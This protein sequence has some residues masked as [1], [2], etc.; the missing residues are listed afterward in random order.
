MR[1]YNFKFP[2]TEGVYHRYWLLFW[3]GKLFYEKGNIKVELYFVNKEKCDDKVSDIDFNKIKVIPV[4]IAYLFEL[5]VGFV[6]DG[7]GNDVASCGV[8]TQKE[9]IKEVSK[10]YTYKT[11]KNFPL[12]GNKFFLKDSEDVL[13]DSYSYHS[14]FFRS[15]GR[16][17]QALISPYVWI[18]FF[19]QSSRLVKR[20]FTGEVFT[21][22]DLATIKYYFDSSSNKKIAEL[23]YDQSKYK[24]REVYQ[25]VPH[26]F[27]SAK[28]GIKF[29]N[30]I[31]SSIL[32][33]FYN[34]ST[35]KIY[36]YV[37]IKYENFDIELE[38]KMVYN[39]VNGEKS[40]YFLVSSIKAL[41]F[42]GNNNYIIDKV[43]LV[44]YKSK[45]TTEDRDNHDIEEVLS[46]SDPIQESAVLIL[47][48]EGAS[49]QN[50][51][52]T[53]AQTEQDFVSS[54]TIEFGKR[55]EQSGSYSVINK[56]Q[57]QSINSLTRDLNG[58]ATDNDTVREHID[59]DI[60]Q[61]ERISNFD[62]FCEV[63]TF[64]NTKD[65]IYV[66]T[67]LFR[68]QNLKGILR[69]FGVMIAE[70]EYKGKYLYLIEFGI[71][72]I[73][74]FSNINFNKISNEKLSSLIRIF[75]RNDANANLQHTSLWTYLFNNSRHFEMDYNIAIYRGVRHTRES[76]STTSPIRETAERILTQRVFKILL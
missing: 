19:F 2:N 17:I 53:Q 51:I 18:Q 44:P 68:R 22:L 60:V 11:S 3:I 64:L 25:I 14:I 72:F 21:G 48:G 71:S 73:G 9:Y 5:K 40:E 43:S 56:G 7:I 8:Y 76:K 58:L 6:Y 36:P 69:D 27:L 38:G 12:V 70:I 66:N 39:I 13:G 28:K 35:S 52:D 57:D 31:S 29:L 42:N 10:V 41:R 30:S 20:L 32:S 26:L 50:A 34:E 54:L 15:Y 24:N 49:S 59:K 61:I 67:G 45:T 23:Y 4:H 74:V 1:N 63:I 55:L 46:N 47:N 75:K 33:S 37:Y 65:S 62:F 16:D